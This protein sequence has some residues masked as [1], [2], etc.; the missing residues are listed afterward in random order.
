MN[1]LKARSFR[2]LAYHECSRDR[3]AWSRF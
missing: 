2:Y 1:L 3:P